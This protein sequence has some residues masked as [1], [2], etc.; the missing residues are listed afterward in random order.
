MLL[1][2]YTCKAGQQLPLQFKGMKEQKSDGWSIL[3]ECQMVISLCF[4]LLIELA[5][6][7]LS[8]PLPLLLFPLS[9][10]DTPKYWFPLFEYILYSWLKI[11]WRYLSRSWI[12]IRD[13]SVVVIWF[14]RGF[15]WSSKSLLEVLESHDSKNLGLTTSI[16]PLHNGHYGIRSHNEH[17]KSVQRCTLSS[18]GRKAQDFPCTPTDLPRHAKVGKM[19]G[20]AELNAGEELQN[21]IIRFLAAT[22][23]SSCCCW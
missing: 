6:R 3:S 7:H 5:A 1:P 14:S 23:S 18:D 2:F 16:L 17:S 21:Q 11:I 20:D 22:A 12:A 13:V 4:C 15:N 8:F 10:T 19:V 9:H